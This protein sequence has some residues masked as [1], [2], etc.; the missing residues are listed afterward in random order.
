M[1][2]CVRGCAQGGA[3]RC[4]W[5]GAAMFIYVCMAVWPWDTLALLEGE[6]MM[7]FITPKRRSPRAHEQTHEHPPLTPDAHTH[8][9]TSSL[10][11]HRRSSRPGLHLRREGLGGYV[12]LR[13]RHGAR[14]E[15]TGCE[16]MMFMRAIPE[17][18]RVTS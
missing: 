6:A 2:G 9:R 8:A 13:L 12:G 17:G 1:R 16:M 7:M 5:G 3:A 10:P 18:E 11:V 14:P 15:G 4:S